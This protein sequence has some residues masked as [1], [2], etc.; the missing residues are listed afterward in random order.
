MDYSSELQTSVPNILILSPPLLYYIDYIWSLIH[1]RHRANPDILSL[2][3]IKSIECFYVSVR[4]ISICHYN[5][6]G[7]AISKILSFI[8][9][10]FIR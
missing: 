3:K 6:L 9:Q 5:V 4:D 1:M 7:V 10:F 2:Q 8:D